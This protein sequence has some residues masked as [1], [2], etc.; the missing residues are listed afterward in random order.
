MFPESSALGMQR[1]Q[2]LNSGTVH[3]I[4]K[5]RS[6]LLYFLI[7]AGSPA[8]FHIPLMLSI[9]SSLYLFP[10]LPA[11]SFFFFF[12]FLSQKFYTIHQVSVCNFKQEGLLPVCNLSSVLLGKNSCS[13]VKTPL[14]LIFLMCLTPINHGYVLM[15]LKNFHKFF[16]N[17]SIF[18]SHTTMFKNFVLS[19]ISYKFFCDLYYFLLFVIKMLLN[20]AQQKQNVN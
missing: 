2:K 5:K 3:G 10:K 11:S 6:Y 20:L 9:I 19:H 7:H 8:L 17:W 12:F 4:T 16:S 1:W 15:S 18:S 13:P 14:M